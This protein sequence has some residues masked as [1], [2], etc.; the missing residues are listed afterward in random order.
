MKKQILTG[1][2]LEKL[3]LGREDWGSK[4]TRQSYESRY[5]DW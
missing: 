3:V 5:L 1:A 2:M 4:N